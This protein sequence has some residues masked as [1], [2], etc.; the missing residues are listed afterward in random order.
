MKSIKVQISIDMKYDE[1]EWKK[2]S[3]LNWIETKCWETLVEDGGDTINIPDG[4]E[5]FKVEIVG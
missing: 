3:L 2:S 1:K 4:D 5:N